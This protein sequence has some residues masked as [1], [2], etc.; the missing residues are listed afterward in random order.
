MVKAAMTFNESLE[1]NKEAITP[2]LTE[3]EPPQ[4]NIDSLRPSPEAVEKMK[5]A[6][7]LN[8]KPWTELFQILRGDAT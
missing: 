7:D 5:R 8:K 3:E 6:I 1:K 2:E 4:I